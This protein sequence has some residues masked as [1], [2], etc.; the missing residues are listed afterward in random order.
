MNRCNMRKPLIFLVLLFIG[1]FIHAAENSGFMKVTSIEA[2][3]TGYHAIYF[4]GAIPDQGCTL[5]GRAVVVNTNNG[6]TLLS[7]AA[8]ALENNLSVVIKVDGCV[9][10]L[11]GSTAT[12]ALITKLQLT[13]SSF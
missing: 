5:P 9:P 7:L 10:I 12:A 13:N 11:P 2:R 4:N 6:N 3:D 1:Q 8:T